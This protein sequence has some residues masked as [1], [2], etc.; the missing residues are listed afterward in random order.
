MQKKI[1]H[2]WNRFAPLALFLGL[3]SLLWLTAMGCRPK[4]EMDP[5][6]ETAAPAQ[7]SGDKTNLTKGDQALAASDWNGAIEAYTIQ[8]TVNPADIDAL[9]GR[10]A[11]YITLGR[12]HY[13]Q[14]VE[15]AA[16]NEMDQAVEETRKADEAFEQGLADCEEV[17][18]TAPNNADAIYIVGCIR[19]YQG[20]WDQA[21]DSF[22]TVIR[23]QPDNP[24]PYQ[25]RGEV[26]GHIGDTVNETID[27]KRAA[28]LGYKPAGSE[29]DD[30]AQEPV[31][32]L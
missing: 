4:E 32:A 7:T 29:L 18:K 23:L 8:L 5:P 10:S 9:I 31:P 6:G 2:Y 17:L 20:E 21:I 13:D 24:Y 11:A 22:S 1:V 27:L 25:R 19:L 12:A 14:A 30:S 26:F 15:S 28:E 16:L 3:T